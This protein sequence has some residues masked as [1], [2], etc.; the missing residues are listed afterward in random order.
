MG[1]I[2]L[3]WRCEMPQIKVFGK[4]LSEQDLKELDALVAESGCDVAALEVIESV[5]PPSCADS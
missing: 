1:A 2:K 4:K 5:G 3:I